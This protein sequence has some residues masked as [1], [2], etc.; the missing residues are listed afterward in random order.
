M[1]TDSQVLVCPSCHLQLHWPWQP[2]CRKWW[3]AHLKDPPCPHGIA[4]THVWWWNLRKQQPLPTVLPPEKRE[5]VVVESWFEGWRYRRWRVEVRIRKCPYI[6][7]TRFS[8]SEANRNRKESTRTVFNTVF[9]E[10][11]MIVLCSDDVDCFL[12]VLQI[13]HNPQE[14]TYCILKCVKSDTVANFCNAK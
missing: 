11:Q 13:P 3:S 9:L 7:T 12:S 1:V 5:S 14:G 8:P 4:A 2:A 6:K 10:P